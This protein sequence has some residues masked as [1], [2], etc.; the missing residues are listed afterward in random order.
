MYKRFF[1][2]P[3][4]FLF[5]HR[6]GPRILEVGS[7]TGS[8]VLGSFPKHVCGL[9]INPMAVEYCRRI[10]LNVQLINDNGSFPIVDNAFDAC[11]L[12]NVL[13]H[14]VDPQKTI[15]E[16]YRV[17]GQKGGLVIAVPG[18]RGFNSDIDHKI[19]YDEAKLRILDNRYS[20]VN[21]FSMPFFL[22][23]TK[24]SNFVRQYCLVAVYRKQPL[25]KLIYQ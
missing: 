12:D 5:A 18:I 3:I 20:L 22:T 24:L 6:F 19:Y 14:I 25:A 10:G 1:S 23:S 11:C 13:E 17:T 7:G 15:D 16:C 21:L 2:S 9:D 4:L 8:G